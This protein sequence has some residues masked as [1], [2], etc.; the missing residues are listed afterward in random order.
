M[1]DLGG[2]EFLLKTGATGQT[3]DEGRGINLS[4]SALG[5]V[6]AA[7]GRKKERSRSLYIAHTKRMLER[8]HAPVPLQREQEQRNAIENSQKQSSL[9]CIVSDDLA[10]YPYLLF[11]I[12]LVIK[13][14]N[15]KRIAEQMK[16]AEEGCTELGT[17]IQK[18]DFL[19]SENRRQNISHLKSQ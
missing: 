8:Q 16:E 19:L 10:A 2:S 11:C 14:A 7:L 18:A 6:I 15:R 5:D 9:F 3:L 13:E 4:L 12:P 1:V 17:Q